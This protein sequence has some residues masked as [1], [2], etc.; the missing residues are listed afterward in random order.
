MIFQSYRYFKTFKGPRCRY[1]SLL[2]VAVLDQLITELQ[3]SLV[4]NM[5]AKYFFHPPPCLQ[6]T[7]P[8]C[9]YTLGDKVGQTLMTQM[10]VPQN[11]SYSHLIFN[12]S[13]ETEANCTTRN[14]LIFP[15][16]E[17]ELNQTTA[18]IYTTVDTLQK[19][20]N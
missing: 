12:M 18:L 16:S 14:N 15:I 6:Q 19:K 2:S 5:A 7:P 4:A 1:V 13:S 8:G 3:L 10:F 17:S 9:D 11:L 20:P